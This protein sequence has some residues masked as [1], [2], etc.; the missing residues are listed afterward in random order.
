M[1]VRF[2]KQG[3][4]SG[5]LLRARLEAERFVGSVNYG[6]GVNKRVALAKMAQAGIP[7]PEQYGKF[8]TTFP[9]VGRPDNHMAGRGFWY[10]S[11][12]SDARLA[13]AGTRRKRAATHFMAYE[14]RKHEFRVFLYQGLSI[15]ISEKILI[16]DGY[17]NRVQSVRNFGNGYRFQYPHWFTHKLTLRKLAK[18]AAEAIGLDGICAVDIGWDE[19]R[20]FVVYE[21][22]SAPCLTSG[23]SDTLDRYVNAIMEGEKQGD[24]IRGTRSGSTDTDDDTVREHMADLWVADAG[25]WARLSIQ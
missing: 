24:G 21:V 20:G 1:G 10:C 22:N 17:W 15:K 18:E 25:R 9:C 4:V 16:A 3:C 8:P 12:E 13:R 23:K 2:S 5:R 14:P 11:R 6:F 19:S 7:V